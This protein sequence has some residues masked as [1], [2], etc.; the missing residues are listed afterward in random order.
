MWVTFAVI[1]ALVASLVVT[2]GVNPSPDVDYHLLVWLMVA[3]HAMTVISTL[4]RIARLRSKYLVSGWTQVQ[5]KCWR[6]Y[7]LIRWPVF[8]ACEALL[9]AALLC[10][11]LFYLLAQYEQFKQNRSVQVHVGS[12]MVLFAWLKVRINCRVFK[13]ITYRSTHPF[14]PFRSW[15]Q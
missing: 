1:H 6:G 13:A 3:I 15:Q 5:V 11:T 8:N 4:L 10:T 14:F 12:W 2:F 9:E 7:R